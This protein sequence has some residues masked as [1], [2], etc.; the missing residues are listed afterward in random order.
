MNNKYIYLGL[1]CCILLCY[2]IFI[3]INYYKNKLALNNKLV[4]NNKLNLPTI[5]SDGVISNFDTLDINTYY[6]I[7]DKINSE[8]SI[9]FDNPDLSNI[10]IT[11][12]VVGGGGGGSGG[13]SNIKG[14]DGFGGEVKLFVI[15]KPKILTNTLSIEI[16]KGGKYGL[17]HTGI[18]T[19][20]DNGQNG[21]DTFIRANSKLINTKAKGGIGGYNRDNIINNEYNVN[22]LGSIKKYSGNGINN[23]YNMG[24]GGLGGGIASNGSDGNNGCVI[25]KLEYNT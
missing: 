14:F 15:N 25:I 9:V 20:I 2:I 7:F 16:G 24:S 4:L 6:Y 19:E 3:F 13:N 17:G 12:L 18:N 11:F 8:N 10:N 23:I 22:I 21:N 5:I 1:V